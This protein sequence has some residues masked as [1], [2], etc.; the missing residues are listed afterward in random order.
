MLQQSIEVSLILIAVDIDNLKIFKLYEHPEI[1]TQIA[2]MK[3]S[4]ILRV[5]CSDHQL[6]K[7][8]PT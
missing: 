3:K 2:V 5:V 8:L 4:R 6:T 1:R 7:L